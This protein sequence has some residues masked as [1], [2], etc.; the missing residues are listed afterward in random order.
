LREPS[1]NES[2]VL[3]EIKDIGEFFNILRSQ[4]L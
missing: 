4:L 1:I 3:G 2:P